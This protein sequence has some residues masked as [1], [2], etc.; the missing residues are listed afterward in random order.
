MCCLLYQAHS[1]MLFCAFNSF[2]SSNASFLHWCG[3]PVKVHPRMLFPE[4][5]PNVVKDPCHF[6]I[7]LWSTYTFRVKRSPDT[8][9][10]VYGVVNHAAIFVAPSCVLIENEAPDMISALLCSK[11][12]SIGTGQVQIG[13]NDRCSAASEF[14]SHAVRRSSLIAIT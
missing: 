2:D 5:I 10:T 14:L 12:L 11:A 4:S 9:Q 3:A 1:R 6:S 13:F 7:S 8:K